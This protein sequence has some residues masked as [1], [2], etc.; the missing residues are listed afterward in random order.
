MADSIIK[1][2][3]DGL[4]EGKL[5][6]THCDFCDAYTFPP[7][8]ACEHCGNPDVEWVEL[9]GKGTLLFASHGAAPPPNA[10]FVDIAPYTYGHI[11]LA[12]GPVVQ[13]IITGVKAEPEELQALFER[14]PVPVEPDILTLM[15][16]K[17]LA[18]KLV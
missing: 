7:T 8:T 13:G 15:G 4:A 14:G 3:Y 17:V 6:A 16:L 12:E 1:R 2:Y 9:S 11:V 5:L 18:W 10:R